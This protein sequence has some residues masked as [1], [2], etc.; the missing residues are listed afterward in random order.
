MTT[1]GM[2]G[3]GTM[4]AAMVERMLAAGHNVVVHDARR[5][6]AAA[7]EHKGAAW[8]AS[9]AE[10]AERSRLVLTSLPGPT[11]VEKVCDGPDGI[12]AT[13]KAGDVHVGL[14]TVSVDA[15]R[16]I[17]ERA[18]EH[19]ML[20]LDAP[21]SGGAAG[22][23]SGTLAVLASG[24]RDALNA[25]TPVLETF[26][27]R[28][29]DLGSQPGAGTLAKLV[30]NAIFLCSGLVHQEAV[31]L[32]ARAGI[33]PVALDDV[34]CAS[35]ASMYLGL[36]P[37]T[38]ARQWEPPFFTV[39]L[40]EKDIALALES[41]RTLAVP[42]PVVAAAHQHYLDAVA[43]GYGSRLFCSTLAVIEEAAGVSVPVRTGTPMTPE[44]KA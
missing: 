42:M 25:A 18:A 16:R 30:N 2:I 22:V 38:L 5:G 33:D 14:S 37:L 28:I 8:A 21:V 3:T 15:A 36:A 34:L 31:A 10:V 23:R 9:P 27:G 12:L 39:G 6:A 1:V 35:S 26:A 13:S 41:A 29:F 19:G 20:Y 44:E 4:G 43:A 17:A 40:A 24:D 7:L 32:A 11:E